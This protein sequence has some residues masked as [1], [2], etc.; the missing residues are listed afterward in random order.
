MHC[1]SRLPY[2]LFFLK[3]GV[4]F[5]ILYFPGVG[6]MF[7]GHIHALLGSIIFLATMALSP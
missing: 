2:S 3:G 1:V 6:V 7:F 5:I 4:P